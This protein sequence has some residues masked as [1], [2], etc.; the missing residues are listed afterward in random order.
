[1]GDDQLQARFVVVEL[2]AEE[3]YPLRLAVL[4]NDTPS[5]APGFTEDGL[6]GTVHLGI[7]VG[8]Q[9]V[10]IS[11]WVLRPYEGAPAVQVRGMATAAE[12]RGQG[13]GGLLLEAGCARAALVG[14]LVW[15][16]ARDTALPF[17]LRHGFSVVGD[18]FVDDVTGKPHHVITR[19]LT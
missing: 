18:G 3:T 5:R 12:L 14:P 13:L 16:R 8:D 9:V 17:Y 19:P 1:M 10:A 11:T 2:T 7:R 4:R 15:A 6:P